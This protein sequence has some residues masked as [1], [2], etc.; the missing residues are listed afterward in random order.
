M[1]QDKRLWYIIVA[2][3][4][5]LVFSYAGGFLGDNEPASEEQTTN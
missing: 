5:V 1:P 3:I 4:A 2:V